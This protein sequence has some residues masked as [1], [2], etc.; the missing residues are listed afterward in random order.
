MAKAK[1]YIPEG[2]QS[3]TASLVI[4][5]A[6]QAID[7]YK[8]VLGASER[9][10]RHLGPDG[11]VMHSEVQV[12]SSVLFINDVM[13]GSPSVYQDGRKLG[14]SPVALTVYIEDA[15]NVFR[16]ASENGAKVTMPIG[17]QFW[18]DRWGSF[19]DPFGLNWSVATHKEDLTPDEMEN[20]AQDFFR[21]MASQRR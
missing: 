14:G 13:G 11:K 4:D 6:A 10:K 20:R 5:G 9:G 21:Q 19:T 2:L 12:G 18:G 17:D 1:R 3:V 8:K 16:K 7:W 15:D